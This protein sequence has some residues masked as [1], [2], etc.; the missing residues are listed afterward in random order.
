MLRDARSA[1]L[2]IRVSS[3]WPGSSRPSTSMVAATKEDVDALDK[4]GHDELMRFA[5]RRLLRATTRHA[6]TPPRPPKLRRITPARTRCPSG[7][8][9]DRYNLTPFRRP[10][11]VG[12][13]GVKPR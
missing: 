9:T 12:G 1:L 7:P 4:R 8:P 6:K 11:N 10:L 5:L 3:S 13:A 2:S